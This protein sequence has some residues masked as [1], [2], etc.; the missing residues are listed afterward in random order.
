M[1]HISENLGLR[2]I[3]LSDL[4]FFFNRIT[5]DHQSSCCQHILAK[6]N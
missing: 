1:G 2:G 3:A 5:A 6:T 4:I